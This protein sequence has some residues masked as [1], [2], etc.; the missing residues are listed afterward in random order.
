MNNN[1]ME[2]HFAELIAPDSLKADTYSSQMDEF[3]T[4]TEFGRVLSFVNENPYSFI[5]L[6]KL[7]EVILSVR[8]VLWRDNEGN[9]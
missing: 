5:K 6:I 8:D 7:A 2:E 9:C 1:Y 4:V 3:D